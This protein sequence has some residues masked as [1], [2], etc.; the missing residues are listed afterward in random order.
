VL[1]CVLKKEV[2]S[3]AAKAELNESIISHN[4]EHN[5]TEGFEEPLTLAV[6]LISQDGSLLGST[7]AKYAK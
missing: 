6:T 5:T 7:A 2:A 4:L 3:E 1:T